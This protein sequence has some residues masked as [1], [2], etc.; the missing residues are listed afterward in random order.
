MMIEQLIDLSHYFGRGLSCLPGVEGSRQRQRF[1]DS[2]LE[3]NVRRNLFIL[4][5][6]YVLQQKPHQPLSLTV[7]CVRVF[8]YPWKILRQVCDIGTLLFA[9]LSSIVLAM[10]L[11]LFLSGPQGPK[12]IIPVSLKGIGYQPVCGINVKVASL[13]QI[14]L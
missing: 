4:D 3:A 6:S 7:R 2:A 8:P 1:R 13:S 12:P 11:I 9:D 5:E 10:R 14:C